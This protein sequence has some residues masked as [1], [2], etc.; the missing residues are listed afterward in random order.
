MTDALDISALRELKSMIGGDPGDLAELV[1]DFTSTLPAQ[2][3]QLQE[4]SS[5]GDLVALRIAAHSCKSNAR[6]LGALRLSKLCAQ[7]ESESA[8]GEVVDIP[9]HL[10]QIATAI[11]AALLNFEQLDLADV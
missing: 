4:H 3:Q 6:D 5:T 8:A 9:S 11:E 1:E 2:L 7:L 10:A